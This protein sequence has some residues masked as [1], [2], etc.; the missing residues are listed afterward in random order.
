MPFTKAKL[1]TIQQVILCKKNIYSVCHK[2]FKDFFSK[3]ESSEI[4]L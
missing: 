3:Q 1:Q 2:S 4:G